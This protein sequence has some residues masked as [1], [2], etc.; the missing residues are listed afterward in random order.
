MKNGKN[1]K[2]QKMQLG[3][4][5]PMFGFRT[6]LTKEELKPGVKATGKFINKHP[7]SLLYRLIRDA[8]SFER[9]PYEGSEEEAQKYGYKHYTQ[10]GVTKAVRYDVEGSDTMTIQQRAQAQLDKYGITQEQAQDKSPGSLLLYK[11][12]PPTPEYDAV[13]FISNYLHNNTVRENGESKTEDERFSHRGA[14]RLQRNFAFF[15]DASAVNAQASQVDDLLQEDLYNYYAG[16]PIKNGTIQVYPRDT[17]AGGRKPE[18][19]AHPYFIEVVD[20]DK[21]IFS[22]PEYHQS[23]RRNWGDYKQLSGDK[24]FGSSSGSQIDSTGQLTHKDTFDINPLTALVKNNSKL[25]TRWEKRGWLDNLNNFG[26]AFEVYNVESEESVKKRKEQES[27][28]DAKTKY[29]PKL[30]SKPQAYYKYLKAYLQG[31]YKDR[32]NKT[33]IIPFKPKN[34]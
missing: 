23:N 34:N 30:V 5:H 3:G 24:Y 12:G 32:Q 2:I 19:E 25:R 15:N 14:D 10:N 33:I 9:Q 4:V 18:T 1:N 29:H 7:L 13:H 17:T 27:K 26:Q 20:A 28:E 21:Y 22:R 16:F 31:V 11:Y 6:D 8:R